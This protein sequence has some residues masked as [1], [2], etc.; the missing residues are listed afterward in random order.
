MVITHASC[1]Y[2]CTISIC[3]IFMQHKEANQKY[4]ASLHCSLH[5][6]S[7]YAHPATGFPRWRSPGCTYKHYTIWLQGLL[8]VLT[9]SASSSW[10]RWKSVPQT[11]CGPQLGQTTKCCIMTLRGR[12]SRRRCL[13]T[14]TQPTSLKWPTVIIIDMCGKITN[15]PLQNTPFCG[16]TGNAKL[17]M[18]LL[19]WFW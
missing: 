9:L 4:T 2:N 16:H 13:R 1:L 7:S 8:W 17:K 15:Y 19:P 5:I 12:I 10:R 6:H 14:S 3:N 11:A 18:Y